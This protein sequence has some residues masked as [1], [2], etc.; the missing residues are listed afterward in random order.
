MAE[1]NRQSYRTRD[2]LSPRGSEAQARTQAEDPLAELARLI[3]Q[4]GPINDLGRDDRY[5]DD[6][7]HRFVPCGET[8]TRSTR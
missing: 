7:A 5:D 4:K 2:A 6:G 8:E 1:N 3:G